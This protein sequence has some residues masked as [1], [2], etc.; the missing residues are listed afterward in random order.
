MVSGQL[1]PRDV[2]RLLATLEAGF[3]VVTT[4]P[5]HKNKALT[6]GLEPFLAVTGAPEKS[7]QIAGRAW[8]KKSL[9][10][11]ARALSKDSIVT[12]FRFSPTALPHHITFVTDGWWE[13]R[14]GVFGRSDRN[15]SYF[16]WLSFSRR[17][18]VE[19][20][21]LERIRFLTGTAINPH[22]TPE[23]DV[24]GKCSEGQ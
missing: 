5:I 18:S 16:R 9:R 3:D 13:H 22:E 24:A 14:G 19:W 10:K 21:R 1:E 15:T 17:I 20:S 7:M 8:Q 2:A 4:L 11:Q 6:S 23:N 12:Q